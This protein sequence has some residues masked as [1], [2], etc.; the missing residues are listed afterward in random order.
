M[1]RNYWTVLVWNGA[2][3]SFIPIRLIE[4]PQGAKNGQR[5]GDDRMHVGRILPS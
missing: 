5:W 1:L 3:L 4:G 2:V